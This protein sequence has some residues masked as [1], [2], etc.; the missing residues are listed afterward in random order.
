VTERLLASAPQ[1]TVCA[2]ELDPAMASLVRERLHGLLGS[3]LTVIDAS[4]SLLPLPDDAFDLTLARF[5][6]QHLAAPDLATAELFRMLKPGGRIAIIDADDGFGGVRVP[7][8]P[9]IDRAFQQLGALGDAI[10]LRPTL[11][12]AAGGILGA[13]RPGVPELN[14]CEDRWR[15]L[16]AVV[17]ANRA[18]PSVDELAARASAWLDALAPADVLRFTG[19]RSSKFDWLPT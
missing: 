12:V 7:S 13:C 18:S 2:V 9:A 10:G 11:L 19:L 16:K 4:A 6:F 15:R 17:A 8:V 1:G 5:V 3:R 14:P